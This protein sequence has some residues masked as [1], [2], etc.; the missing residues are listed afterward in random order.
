[1]VKHTQTIRPL[2]LMNCLGVFDYFVGLAF[3]ALNIQCF[4]ETA[5]FSDIQNLKYAHK[6]FQHAGENF[7]VLGNCD[8]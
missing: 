4:R 2:L 8:A 1:M 7:L 6:N 5:F 3:K